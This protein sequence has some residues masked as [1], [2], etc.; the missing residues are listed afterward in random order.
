MGLII[1]L[2]LLW[3]VLAVLGF[4]IKSLFWLAIVALVLFVAT[5]VFGAIRR[6]AAR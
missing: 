1:G 2:L 3:L 5:G 6:R 4:A